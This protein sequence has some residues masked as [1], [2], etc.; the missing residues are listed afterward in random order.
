MLFEAVVLRDGGESN[1][2]GTYGTG[3]NTRQG[4]A[5]QVP[6]LDA[7]LAATVHVPAAC[8]YSCS[9]CTSEKSKR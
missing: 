4:R 7:H 8:C 3:V 5:L 6:R 9:R 2:V 1:N